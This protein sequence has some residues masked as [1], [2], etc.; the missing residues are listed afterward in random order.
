MRSTRTY[1]I[2]AFTVGA[3]IFA[4]ACGS[5][6][7]TQPAANQT[8]RH[9]RTSPLGQPKLDLSPE[10]YYATT[11]FT[12]DPTASTYI[13]VGPH[14]LYIPAGAVCDPST[15]GYGIDTWNTACSSATASITVTANSSM[16][17]GHPLVTF[18][19]HLRFK[20]G[21][22]SV[23][24]VMLYI[25]D[26]AANAHSTIRWCPDSSTSCVNEGIFATGDQLSTK[27]DAQGNWVYRRLKHFSGFNV[28]DDSCDPNVDPTCGG[29]GL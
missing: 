7:T 14:Y 13:A 3:A 18:D 29:G 12:I 23:G 17:N 15:S 27:F 26:D 2:G 5:D 25:R 22:D 1:L 4:V 6:V 16:L 9:F 8:A 28:S 24:F 19:T 20:P 11:T 10:Q 21:T